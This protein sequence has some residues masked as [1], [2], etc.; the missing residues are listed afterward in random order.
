MGEPVK[1]LK[2]A[3][4]LLEMFPHNNTSIEIIGL[5]PGEK[6]YEELLCKSEEIL[7]TSAEKIMILKQTDQVQDFINIYND[8]I[9]NYVTMNIPQLKQALKNIISEYVYNDE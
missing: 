6:L 8:L 2:L 4:N 9:Q 3:E 1:I 5:R 7:P